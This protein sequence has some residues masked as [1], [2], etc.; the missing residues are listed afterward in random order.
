MV[1]AVAVEGIGAVAEP[2]PPVGTVYQYNVFPA[3]EVAVKSEAVT[4]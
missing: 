2:V 1:P 3:V 4:P